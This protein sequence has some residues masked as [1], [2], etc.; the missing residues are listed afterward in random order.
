MIDTEMNNINN[1]AQY[2]SKTIDD[3]RD[4]IKGDTK[5]EDIQIKD[6]VDSTLSIVGP[7]LK[8]NYIDIKAHILEI[9][10]LKNHH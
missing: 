2:L 9:K 6:V 5:F 1:S 7:S 4:F 8:N 3:F 10:P